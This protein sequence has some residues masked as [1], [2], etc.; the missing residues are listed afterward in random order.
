MMLENG[1]KKKTP[2]RSL[3]SFHSGYVSDPSPCEKG[4]CKKGCCEGEN[5]ENLCIHG[6]VQEEICDDECKN[7][8]KRSFPGT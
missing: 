8:E 2:I 7:C 4:N 3:F 5:G 1:E 6:S